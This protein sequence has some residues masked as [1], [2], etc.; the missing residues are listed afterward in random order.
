LPYIGAISGIIF[1]E[2]ALNNYLL[3]KTLLGLH[4]TGAKSNHH[5][6]APATR[7]GVGWHQPAAQPPV[8]KRAE[9]K[10]KERE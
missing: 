2:S 4:N 10:Q 7:R 9:K 6:L 5:A 8:V 3:M 1:D